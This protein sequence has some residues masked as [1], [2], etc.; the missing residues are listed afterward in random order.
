MV[1][2][3][4]TI[5]MTTGEKISKLRKENNYTQEQLAE[6][7]GVSRQSISK[8]ESGIV[9]PETEK[10]IKLSEL[11]GCTVDYLLKDYV[12]MEKGNYTNGNY[13]TKQEDI[14]LGKLV[15]QILS[16]DKKSKKTVFG[17]PLWHVGKNAKGFIAVGL[18]AQGIISIGLLSIG[19]LSF[20]MLSIG[21]LAAGV[22]GIGVLAA[23]AFAL[24]GLVCGAICAGVI[25]VGAIAIGEFSIGALAIGH[26]FA[27]GDYAKAIFAFGDT[28]AYGSVFECIR[29][30]T[31]YEREVIINEM[32]E[33]IPKIYHWI[34]EWFSGLI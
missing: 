11:F 6:L 24:G 19:V 4:G 29:D 7:L 12:E 34:V 23:G 26:Y 9:Y 18:K 33:K 10:L 31:S 30:V 22:F 20:G 8:Y 21:L 25:A 15:Q 2:Q 17:M 16:F 3:E 14:T 1:K 27:Y 5:F 13:A 32:Y 28:E